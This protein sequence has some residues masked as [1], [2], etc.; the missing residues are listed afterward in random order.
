[1]SEIADP[2]RA[3]ARESLFVEALG[4]GITLEMVPIPGGTFLMGAPPD[5]PDSNNSERPQHLVTVPPFRLGRYVVTIAQWR[6]VMGE[7][8]EGVMRLDPRFASRDDLP[9]VRV[10]RLEADAFCSELSARTGRSYR[11]PS[12]AEWEYACRAGTTTAFWFGPTIDP[13]VV[14][15]AASGRGMTVPVGSL[16][17]ANAFGLFDMHG[18]VWELCADKWNGTHAGAPTDGSAREVGED[19]R[20]TVMRGGSWGSKKA[21][22]C[23]S[24]SRMLVGNLNGRSRQFGFRVALSGPG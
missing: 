3:A 23:R 13:D 19:P 14:N 11:L 1:V 4:N 15:F 22:S 8:P 12:E 16:G 24:A 5:E 9:V 20:T 18:N 21:A 7:L 17:A 2:L 6:A 10:C